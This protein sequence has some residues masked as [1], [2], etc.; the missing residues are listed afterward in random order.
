MTQT[1]IIRFLSKSGFVVYGPDDDGKYSVE[2]EKGLDAAGLLRVANDYR[3]RY[4]LP[5][6]KLREG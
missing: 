5:A 4:R 1:E 2:K 3:R 6:F